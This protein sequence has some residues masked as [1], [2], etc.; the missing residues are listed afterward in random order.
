VTSDSTVAER[1][2]ARV[3]AE[4]PLLADHLRRWFVAHRATPREIQAST[5]LDG[6]QYIGVW[7]VTDHTGAEDSAYRVVY[8]STVD[9][10]GI[11]TDLQTGVS[12]YLGSY[13]SLVAVVEGL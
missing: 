13:G 8:D 3:D 12:W 5:D 2:R 11:V 7:L 9:A 4:L 10:F 1:I 6:S